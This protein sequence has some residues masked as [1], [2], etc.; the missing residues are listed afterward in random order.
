MKFIHC[1]GHSSRR[2]LQNRSASL[3]L[4]IPPAKVARIQKIPRRSDNRHPS[5]HQQCAREP[6][7]P[8]TSPIFRITGN[9]IKDTLLWNERRGNLKR[10]KSSR[11][12]IP[13]GNLFSPETRGLGVDTFE[14]VRRV[15]NR[16]RPGPPQRPR[17]LGARRA[18][19]F[20]FRKYEPRGRLADQETGERSRRYRVELYRRVRDGI[21][22]W[23][24]GRAKQ[25]GNKRMRWRWK[26][27]GGCFSVARGRGVGRYY[28]GGIIE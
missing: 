16:Y 2:F 4:E 20:T 19:R 14:A 26:A 27:M 28:V 22:R 10:G 17:R 6:G 11:A 21:R 23:W 1:G 9:R 5:I 12:S 15:M 8:V 13:E 3:S 24:W 7:S 25:T 18:K